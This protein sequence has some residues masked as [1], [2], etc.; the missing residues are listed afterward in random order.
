[1]PASYSIKRIYKKGPKGITQPRFCAMNAV[2]KS[3]SNES[4][5]CVYN[6]RV[7]SALAQTLHTP[8]AAG[9]FADTPDQHSFASLQIA[10]PGVALPN[11]RKSWISSAAISY[12]EHVAAL[13]AFDILIG[14]TDRYQNLKVS[15]FTKHVEIFSAFDHSHSLLHPYHAPSTSIS[16]FNSNKLIVDTHTFYGHVSRKRLWKWCKRFD[17]APD[18]LI[19]ECCEFGKPI[20]TVDVQTQRK[21]ADALILRKKVLLNIVKS[22]EHIIKSIP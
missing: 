10:N 7:A 19:K 9:V 20:N 16:L 6:E 1:M 8:N 12:P 21:L 22:H 4:P 14:N 11:I 17:D 3:D 2:L 5:Q 13:V 18:Y 15:L